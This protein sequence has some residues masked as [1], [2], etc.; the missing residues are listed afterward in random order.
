MDI[1]DGARLRAAFLRDLASALN[2]KRR[3]RLLQF[4]ANPLPSPGYVHTKS[5][6]IDDKLAVVGS[7]N[8]W[9]PSM[10]SES[11]FSVAIASTVPTKAFPGVPFAHGLRI[12]L[13]ER[14]LKAVPDSPTFERDDD[15]TF[16]D[17]LEVLTG[18][19]TPFEPLQ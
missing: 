5:W 8:Y 4:K 12:S 7:A 16:F 6:I 3:L 19:D 1:P 15:Q 11:E 9:Q 18:E 2:D 13:W 17:E 14:L 10:Q